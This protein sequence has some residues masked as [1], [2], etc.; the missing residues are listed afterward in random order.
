MKIVQVG[1][2]PPP[3]GGISVHIKRLKQRLEENGHEC[4]VF[5][6]G[7][8]FN[9]RI[10][11]FT[12]NKYSLL[13][14]LL[15]IKADVYHFHT[16]NIKIRMLLG[17]FKKI[18][19]KKVVLTIHGNSLIDQLNKHK[20]IRKKILIKSLLKIDHIICVNDN[21]RTRLIEMGFNKDK[22]S[23]IPSFIKPIEIEDDIKKIPKEVWDFI[24]S[25]KF[26]ITANGNIRFYNNTDLYGIDMLIE[27]ID[28]LNKNGYDVGLLFALLGVESQNN[29]ERNYYETLKGKI[30][31]LGL[32]EKI[33]FFEVKDSEFYPILNKSHLF[34]RPTCVDGFGVSISEALSQGV[35]AIASDICKRPEGTLLFSSRDMLDLT[36]K[37]TDI[38]NRYEYYKKIEEQNYPEDYFRKVLEIYKK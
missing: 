14:K 19:K 27:L 20:G 22:V 4:I 24:K 16:I 11:V 2:Y 1:I 18:L 3:L 21:T 12:F 37:T 15:F 36:K 33:Y 34:I 13:F 7:T 38:I 9:A 25:Q 35:P 32:Q 26:L 23:T 5:N 30:Q 17:L 28:S 8:Y 10:N 31:S 29:E 6:E